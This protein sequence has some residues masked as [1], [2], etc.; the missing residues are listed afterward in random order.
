MSQQ[1]LIDCDDVLLNWVKGFRQFAATRLQRSI[2]GEPEGWKMGP[3]LGVN[4]ADANGLILDFNASVHFGRL[5]AI[6]GARKVMGR[7]TSMRDCSE[8]D[9]RFHVVTSC[10]ADAITQG[11]RRHNLEDQFGEGTFDSIH[12]LNLGQSK[13]SVLRAFAPGSI[14]I[15]DNYTNGSMGV[16]AD[17]HV[18]MK[19]RPS[20]EADQKRPPIKNLS[21]FDTW[22]ELEDILT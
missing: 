20:N 19:R 5:E 7:L 16:R 6:E 8:V 1:I 21:W 12:C 13:A 17:H 11:R 22:D 3:W 18:Y 9:Y 15:E 2:T 10:S 14:W 4:D